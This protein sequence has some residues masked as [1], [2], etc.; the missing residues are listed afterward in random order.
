MFCMRK[1][2]ALVIIQKGGLEIETSFHK[3][4]ES[5]ARQVRLAALDSKENRDIL[6]YK[7]TP[8]GETFC[9]TD[10]SRYNDLEIFWKAEKIPER[11]LK[12]QDSCI[13]SI[14]CEKNTDI[15]TMYFGSRNE[16]IS[17]MT[18]RI[19]SSAGYGSLEDLI[20]NAGC[21]NCGFS[22]DESWVVTKD[23]GLVYWNIAVIP[24]C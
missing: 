24:S 16:A 21:G 22:D 10:D 3:T 2:Y 15:Q 5:A 20:E 1:M 13:M 6:P 9:S 23:K 19:M 4:K 12:N 8:E 18:D 11:Y 7:T 17:S 14:F